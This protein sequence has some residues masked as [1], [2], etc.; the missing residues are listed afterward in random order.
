MIL[1]KA[2]RPGE[3]HRPCSSPT[4]KSLSHVTETPRSTCSP[5]RAACLPTVASPMPSISRPFRPG[6]AP[7]A[8]LHALASGAYSHR[9][10]WSRRLHE[11]RG[12]AP[13]ENQQCP[14]HREQPYSPLSIAQRASHE[15]RHRR[16]YCRRGRNADSGMSL[17]L[18]LTARI[19]GSRHHPRLQSRGTR[20][21][22]GALPRRRRSSYRTRSS[23]R[24]F[25][26]R[27]SPNSIA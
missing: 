1:V 6:R 13:G 2:L 20:N 16:S 12:R 21:L 8:R 18:A 7:G 17:A 24:S 10:P 27:P 11:S 14:A 15:Q 5:S 25:R 19:R 22:Y 23:C 4:V 26:A 9:P 3:A